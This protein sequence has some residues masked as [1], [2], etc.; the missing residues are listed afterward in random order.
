M[1]KTI[2]K[3]IADGAVGADAINS[4]ALG[5]G[6][7]GGSG[8][9]VAVGA[10][11]GI[12]V[13]AT[14][15]LVDTTSIVTFLDDAATQWTFP[16]GTTAQGGFATGTPVD[17]NHLVNKG[18]VDSV[19]A[20]TNDAK[21]ACDAGT[22][23]NITNDGTTPVYAN[24]GGASARGQITWTTGPT[25]ID[26]VTLVN[27]MRI[28]VKDEV[29]GLGGDANGIWI[30]TGADTW[31][32]A[33]DY[34]ADAEVTSGNNTWVTGGTTQAQSGWIMTT[35]D[36]VVIGGASGTVLTYVQNNGLSNVSAG[37]G[38]TKSTN[39]LNVGAGNA[40]TVN[41]DDIDVNPAG[42]IQGGAAEIDGDFLDIDYAPTNYTEL[43]GTQG[44]VGSVLV[45]H[46]TSHLAGIDAELGNITGEITTKLTYTLVAGDITTGLFDIVTDAGGAAVQNTQSVSITPV[47]G[48][49]QTSRVWTAAAGADYNVSTNEVR[50]NNNSAETDL[51]DTG[52]GEVWT[53]GDVLIIEY[54]A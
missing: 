15:V 46:L 34:D 9:T 30:R 18:Y 20:G 48:P 28:L 35:A 52:A 6:L 8:T 39:T 10:G 51:T 25:L 3:W 32:R 40:I 49:Q 12:A 31:D 19:A 23:Q 1:S 36:P 11:A 24:A 26:G 7:A 17:A 41:A 54:V 44:G 14:T 29:G 5:D 38:L 13:T 33:T 53:V 37:A 4:D 27:G 47:G 45:D 50:I 22:I 42:L 21:D 43:T 2:R 16:V